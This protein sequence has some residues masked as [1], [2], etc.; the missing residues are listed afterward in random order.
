[1]DIKLSSVSLG[2]KREGIGDYLIFLKLLKCY[3]L[4]FKLIL[5][6]FVCYIL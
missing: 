1:M 5:V 3:K 4:R 6:G 2:V